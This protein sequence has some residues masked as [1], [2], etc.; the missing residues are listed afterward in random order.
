MEQHANAVPGEGHEPAAARAADA[1]ILVIVAELLVEASEP[2]EDFAANE[3]ATTAL[4]V[5]F[6][7][8]I[9][10]PSPVAVRDKAFR[11]HRERTQK[12]RSQQVAPDRWEG[13]S[14]LLI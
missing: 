9:A 8:A 4:P 10:V 13:A 12:E 1:E 5:Y 3:Q 11:D 2:S 7:F 6:A 14:R